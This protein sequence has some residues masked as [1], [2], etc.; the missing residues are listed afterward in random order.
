MH[1]IYMFFLSRKGA[2]GSSLSLF[3]HSSLKDF[4]SKALLF[5]Y[6]FLNHLYS[7]ALC[8]LWI[9]LATDFIVGLPALVIHKI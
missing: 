3:L 8:I 4:S 1:G 7:K 9:L 6:S 2:V 5:V